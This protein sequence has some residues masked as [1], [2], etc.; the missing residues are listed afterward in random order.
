MKNKFTYPSEKQSGE[1]LTIEYLT[2]LA[3]T[4]KYD[5]GGDIFEAIIKIVPQIAVEAIVVDSIV[6]PT[7]VLLTWREDKNYKGWHFPGGFV[8]FGEKPENRLKTVINK[9]LKATVK[10]YKRLNRIYNL[11]DSRGHTLSLCYLVKVNKKPV[12][13][14]WFDKKTPVNIID[15]HRRI[16]STELSWY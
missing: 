10:K 4:K 7:K 9:E 5:L 1:K 3:E 11:I 6:N 2:H 14:S 8:R 12:G 15:H 16:L 13:G